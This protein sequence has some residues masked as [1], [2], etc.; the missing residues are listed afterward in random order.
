MPGMLAEG[1]TPRAAD[2]PRHDEREGRDHPDAQQRGRRTH[3][4]GHGE[5]ELRPSHDREPEALDDRFVPVRRDHR[6]MDDPCRRREHR[7]E[8]PARTAQLEPRTTGPGSSR[9]CPRR[10]SEGLKRKSVMSPSRMRRSRSGRGPVSNACSAGGLASRAGDP[11]AT[12]TTRLCAQNR[13]VS[14]SASI[15]SRSRGRSTPSS[16]AA[17]AACSKRVT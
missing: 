1:K 2:H 17:C 9:L 6:Q 13:I 15:R 14:A 16:T 5:R 3:E 10:A 4:Q 11:A 12:R 7:Q 8:H